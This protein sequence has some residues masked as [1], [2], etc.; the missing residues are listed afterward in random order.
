VDAD[1]FATFEIP[2]LRGR[3]FNS[4]DREGSPDVVVI[5]HKMADM[6][7]PGQDPLGKT[8]SIGD[9]PGKAIV[10]GVTIDGKYDELDE[11]PRP[12]FYR[13]LS[14]HFQDSVSIIARTKG[15]PSLWIEPIAQAVRP[16][17]VIF[18]LRPIT[19]ERWINFTLLME[20]LT[21]GCVAV[22]SALGLLLAVVGLFGAI[23]YSV[24]ERKKELGIRIALGASRWQLA[25]MVLRQTF[26]IAGAGVLIGILLGAGATL[27]LRS[28][29]YGV[30]ALE[31]IVLLPVTLAMLSI[32]LLVAYLSARP[33]IEVDPMQA[34]RH[35]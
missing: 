2:L 31:W 5:N 26:A 8:V 1:Y 19:Y 25:R 3:V 21:A 16:F 11:A 7:W 14:Q 30:G 12:F 24:S 23:S 33:W 34:V 15:D 22:L 20:R 35:A 13:A 4:G 32:S 17:D 10:V 6:F 28:Q 9:P 29:F 27:L 18:L